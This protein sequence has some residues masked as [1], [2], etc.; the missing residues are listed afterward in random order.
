[1]RYYYHRRRLFFFRF[2]LYSS[3]VISRE[4][5][6]HRPSQPVNVKGAQLRQQYY[7]CLLLLPCNKKSSE[8]RVLRAGRHC[9]RRVIP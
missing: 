7:C 3:E 5:G 9:D 8:M 1:M 6:H 2:N 4:T